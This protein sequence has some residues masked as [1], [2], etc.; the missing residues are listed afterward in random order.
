DAQHAV[1]DVQVGGVVPADAAGRLAG[2]GL[3]RRAEGVAVELVVVLELP[4]VTDG[5]FGGR[6]GV[7]VDR[8]GVVRVLV[9]VAVAVGRARR[10]DRRRLLTPRSHARHR[11][12]GHGYYHADC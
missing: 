8:R 1:G 3:P 7:R 6:A 5:R 4:P 11:D 9:A 10:G 2:V 12:R